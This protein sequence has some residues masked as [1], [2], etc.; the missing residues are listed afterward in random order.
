MLI[1]LCST[2]N[3]HEVWYIYDVDWCRGA[4]TS[5]LWSSVIYMQVVPNTRVLALSLN[6]MQYAGDCKSL[7]NSAASS[8]SRGMI[9]E[10]CIHKGSTIIQSTE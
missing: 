2:F 8:P 1:E 5:P 6:V 4:M 9:I 3:T 7:K 10:G